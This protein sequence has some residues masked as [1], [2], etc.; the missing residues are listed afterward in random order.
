MSL[1]ESTNI[2]QI[3]V[4]ENGI[5]LV[6]EATRVYR[7][8]V[9]ISKTYHRYSLE[10]GSDVS[11]MPESVQS[12]CSVSWTDEVIESFNRSKDAN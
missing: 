10:P 1:S 7:D 2:D 12:V 8:E 9:E 5:V 11:H 6:R 3:T 4:C